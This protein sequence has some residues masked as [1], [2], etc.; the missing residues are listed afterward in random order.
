M[1]LGRSWALMGSQNR[2]TSRLEPWVFTAAH[3]RGSHGLPCAFFCLHGLSFAFTV[4]CALMHSHGLLVASHESRKSLLNFKKLSPMVH[5]S[6][7]K[8]QFLHPI[9][10]CGRCALFLFTSSVTCP[11]SLCI[12][13][14]LGPR[15]LKMLSGLFIF[16]CENHDEQSI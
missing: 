9:S 14:L 1:L 16:S 11:A 13:S 8:F 3:G 2:A 12:L 7:C 15:Q 10:G 5:H 6:P 4:L